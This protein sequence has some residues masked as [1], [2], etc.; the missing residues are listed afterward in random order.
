MFYNNF[1]I[2]E[3]GYGL[4][5]RAL[6]VFANEVYKNDDC[7]LYMRVRIVNCLLFYS[8]KSIVLKK[9]NKM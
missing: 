8:N 9:Y 2:L 5:L 3:D 7:T 4:N 1:D 6:A